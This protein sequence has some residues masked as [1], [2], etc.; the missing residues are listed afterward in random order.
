[1]S[2]CPYSVLGVCLTR[3]PSATGYAI[4]GFSEFL[5]ALALLVLVFSSSDFLY[6]FRISVAALPLKTMSFVAVV[7]I[8]AGSLLTDLWFAE[9]WYAPPWGVSRAVLQSTF[10][11]LFLSTVLLWI[12]FAYMRPPVFGRWN[13]KRFYYALFRTVVRGSDAQLAV[14]A[15]ELVGSSEPL[16]RLWGPA[17]RKG[18]AHSP[19][20]TEI[21]AFANDAMLVLNNRKLCRHIVAS[22]PIT[23]IVFMEEAAK[24]KKYSVPLGGFAKKVTE[25]ALRN[26][27]SILFHED[28]YGADVLG[29]VQPFSRAMYGNYRLVEGISDRSDSPLDIDWRLAWEMDGPQFEA[30]CRAAMLTFE[31]YFKSGAY[32]SHSFVLH[33][34]FDIIEGAG[35]EVYTLNNQPSG[36]TI[37]TPVARLSA[38]VHFVDDAIKFL[39]EQTDLK[40]G[41][42]RIRDEAK[43]WQ[44]K[45]IFD[46]I[47]KM[48]TEFVFD[49]SSISGPPDVAWTIH[50]NVVW[51]RLA[52]FREENRATF[53]IRFKF[54]RLLF[55]EI[56]ELETL[57]NF[58]S[59]RILG[60]CLNVLGLSM[61][62]RSHRRFDHPLRVAVL[63]WTQR[64]YLRLREVHPPVAEHCLIGGIS[65]DA[66]NERLVKTYAQGLGLEPSREYLDLDRHA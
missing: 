59:A 20:A 50:Y 63:R 2:V 33:R 45:T 53:V 13:Y 28:T 27:D 5:T 62:K 64:N 30:Y 15:G 6:Q 52:A 38:A 54:F 49:A 31:D 18:K 37:R 12:W 26:R 19:Q 10:G 1:M 47:A 9:R 35:R 65:F 40:F 3:A 32:R 16:I 14:L 7:V 42:L 36:T 56:K 57:P 44:R 17:I 4:F 48:M 25:E 22:A 46:A 55:N 43:Q 66:E 8:G 39:G 58:K 34:A 21:A 24:Q 41:T 11:A 60:Y 51:G 61:E 23:A 29:M